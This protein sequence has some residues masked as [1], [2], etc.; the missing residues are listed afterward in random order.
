[1]PKGPFKA[2]DVLSGSKCMPSNRPNMS[3]KGKMSG[4]HG[5]NSGNPTKGMFHGEGRVGAGT[6]SFKNILTSTPGGD[7]S[8]STRHASQP[9]GKS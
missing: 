8:A 4:A 2:R 5:T 7:K 6:R 9:K 1:M 3:G